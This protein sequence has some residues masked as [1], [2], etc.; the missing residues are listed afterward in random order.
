VQESESPAIRIVEPQ[1]SAAPRKFVFNNELTAESI[2]K[3][4]EDYKAGTLPNYLKSE[5]V[6]EKND[7]PVKTVVGLSFKDI[8]L[9]STK[10]VFI[11][12]YAPWC[13]HCKQLAPIWK[14]LA[15]EL[16]SVENLVIAAMDATANEV[17]HVDISGFPTLKF[18]PANSKENPIDYDG[19]RTK[20]GFLAWLKDRL[21]VEHSKS[22]FGKSD[23]L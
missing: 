14:E 13:G 7:D 12:F 9:D 1:R 18:Y 10:D 8:V 17:E 22:V 15:T 23:E 4:Y 6:P 20:E 3:F 16:S 21:T 19:D 2:V 11:E 5:P